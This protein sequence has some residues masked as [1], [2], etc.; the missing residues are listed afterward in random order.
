MA[1]PVYLP[2][3][4]LMVRQ[5]FLW[6]F[7]RMGGGGSPLT[8]EE[9]LQLAQPPEIPGFRPP[10]H[11]GPFVLGVPAGAERL[12]AVLYWARFL[13]YF[14]WPGVRHFASLPHL[15]LGLLQDADLAAA[16]QTLRN[17]VRRQRHQGL[18]LWR[19]ALPRLLA[20]APPHSGGSSFN[21]SAAAWHPG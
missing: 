11:W 10:H 15:L 18:A 13:D 20:G 7:D 4:Q 2:D 3:L 9:K 1:L 8:E 16:S 14:H 21:A 17:F 6:W 5:P 12:Q 19:D